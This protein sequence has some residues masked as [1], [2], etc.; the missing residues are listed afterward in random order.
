MSHGNIQ[1]KNQVK[2]L[3]RYISQA[4]DET[5]LRLF[6]NYFYAWLLEM[7]YLS[8]NIMDYYFVAQG[9]TSIP[10]VDDGEECELTDVR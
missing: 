2:F 6:I 7:C 4:S 3:F 8:N 1:S 9:K 5:Q 10:G